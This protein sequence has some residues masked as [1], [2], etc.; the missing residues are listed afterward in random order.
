M[1]NSKSSGEE[2]AAAEAEEKQALTTETNQSE[3]AK[4]ENEENIVQEEEEEEEVSIANSKDSS[5]T[6]NDGH[7][8]LLLPPAD[9]LSVPHVTLPPKEVE[10]ELEKGDDATQRTQHHS[11]AKKHVQS[12]TTTAM[13]AVQP[14]IGVKGAIAKCTTPVEFWATSQ[15]NSDYNDGEEKKMDDEDLAIAQPRSPPTTSGTN[16]SGILT[17]AKVVPSPLGVSSMST[18]QSDTTKAKSMPTPSSTACNSGGIDGRSLEE[19]MTTDDMANATMEQK[20]DGVS[21]ICAPILPFS[22]Y[23]YRNWNWFTS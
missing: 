5:A 9:P 21:M 16:T 8:N 23:M 10:E 3:Q 12:E 11:S 14:T 4:E 17:T 6:A 15:S 1:E 13:I 7:V 20:V 19:L 22:L 18:P 2:D